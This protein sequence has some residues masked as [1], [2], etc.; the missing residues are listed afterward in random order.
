[1]DLKTLSFIFNRAL[2][3]TFSRKKNGIVFSILALNG[4]LIVFFQGLAIQA[5]EWI[6]LSLTF[7]PIFLCTGILLSTGIFLTRIYH[8]EVKKKEVNYWGTM[9][10]SWPVVIGASYFSVPIILSYLLLWMLLGV[11]VLLGEMPGLGNFFSIILAFAPFLLNL[12]TLILCVFSLGILFFA[13]PI[14]ALKGLDRYVVFDGL[15]QRLE[16]NPFGNLVLILIALL[17]L[18]LTLALL[19]LS[20]FLT[21]SISL[22]CQTPIQTILKWFFIMFPFTAFLTP[23]IIFFFNFAVESHVLMQK[24]R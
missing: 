20:A 1:M 8:D 18:L 6:R 21:G 14:L 4:L 24:E 15:I 11:F 12:G 13:A 19:M 7:L 17:P 23:S 22:D 9:V 16:K 3:L 5:G 2:S 10:T